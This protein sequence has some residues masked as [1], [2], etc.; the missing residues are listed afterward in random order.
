MLVAS[1][2][3]GIAPAEDED[4]SISCLVYKV[5]GNFADDTVVVAAVDESCMGSGSRVVVDG[6]QSSTHCPCRS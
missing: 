2:D 1:F 5:M 3:G 6:T 4:R